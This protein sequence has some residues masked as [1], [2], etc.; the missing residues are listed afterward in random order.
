MNMKLKL[1]LLFLFFTAVLSASYMH[2]TMYMPPNST[3]IISIPANE[4]DML[5]CSF[6]VV[7]NDAGVIFV[8]EQPDGRI[9]RGRSINLDGWEHKIAEKDGIFKIYFINYRTDAKV[10]LAYRVVPES[11][12]EYK[13][14]WCPIALILLIPFIFSRK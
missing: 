6:E 11:E 4:T 1:F 3:A 8:M 10:Y 12:Q 13:I 2:K 9:Q 7:P 14:D 5:E